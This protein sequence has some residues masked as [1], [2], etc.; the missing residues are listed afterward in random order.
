MLGVPGLTTSWSQNLTRRENVSGLGIPPLRIKTTAASREAGAVAVAAEAIGLPWPVASTL[1]SSSGIALLPRF[2]R[3]DMQ[4][5]AFKTRVVMITGDIPATATAAEVAIP[6]P[7]DRASHLRDHA[8]T[9]QP[10]R[11]VGI[12]GTWP[13]ASPRCEEQAAVFTDPICRFAAA[14]MQLRTDGSRRP[15]AYVATQPHSEA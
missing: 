6:G 15:F 8:P 7:V 3:A 4:L 5:N 11:G 1:G 10:R 12:H 14:S 13:A 2:G 9:R